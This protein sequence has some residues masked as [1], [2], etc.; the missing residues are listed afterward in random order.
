[1]ATARP[2]AVSDGLAELHPASFGW[3]LACCGGDRQEAEDVLQATYVKV[4][5]GSARFDG[6]SAFKTWLFA[7]IRRTAGERRRSRWTRALAFERWWRKRPAEPTIAN[8]EGL[9]DG[10]EA[11][12][13][14]R[15]S[16]RALPGRQRE[17]LH[18]VFYQ[19]LS[20]QEAAEVA[21]IS[22]GSARR[23]YHRG[24]LRLRALIEGTKR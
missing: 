8:P 24:K 23:H 21:G 10:S 6:A 11:C 14:L 3:A 22:V 17:V 7:V 18:L 4:L 16:L 2:V 15:A 13:R 1:M 5:E 9:A 12:R 19:D 20:L